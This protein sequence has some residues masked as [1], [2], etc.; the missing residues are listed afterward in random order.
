MRT[1]LLLVMLILAACGGDAP[2]AVTTPAFNI[3]ANR[4]TVSG[5]SSGAMM[6]TQT[7]VALSDLVQGSAMIAGAG[8]VKP[9][10]IS[11]YASVMRSDV[12][13]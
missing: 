7:H 13:E 1:G 3:D 2:P 6:A 5:V 4:I 9:S 8:L 11:R 12:I 10:G